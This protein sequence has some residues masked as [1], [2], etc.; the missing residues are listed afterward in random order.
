MMARRLYICLLMILSCVC[1]QA[2]IAVGSWKQ[3]PVFGEVTDLID[4][5][6]YVWYATGGCLYSYDK[7]DDETRFYSGCK[8][9]TG[10]TVKFIRHDR[11]SNVLAVAFADG[12]IDM[13]FP[14]G[15]LVNL[16]EIRDAGSGINRAVNDIRFDRNEMFVTTGSGLVI[17]DIERREV[18]ESRIYNM[19]LRT[20]IPTPQYLF[21]ACAEN[22]NGSYALYRVR[23]DASINSFDNLA[24]VCRYRDLIDDFCAL[25]DSGTGYAV[26][27]NGRLDY[28]EI[29][30]GGGCVFHDIRLNGSYCHASG[31]SADDSGVVRFISSDGVVGHY[32]GSG[33][34]VADMAMPEEFR[35]NLMASCRGLA[36]VWLAGP[37]GI[38]NYRIG[39]DLT[40]LREKSVPSDAITFTE[41]SN[42]FPSAGNNGFYVANLGM[43]RWHP[44]GDGDRFNVRLRL[45]NVS[46]DGIKNIDPVGV[47]ANTGP[48]M[49]SQSRYGKYIFSPTGIVEDPDIPG[50][51]YIGSGCEGVYVIEDG[52]EIIKFDNT[53]STINKHADYYCGTVFVTID[54]DGNLWV[55]SRAGGVKHPIAILPADKRKYKDLKLL[56]KEDWIIA[57]YD[58]YL[59]VRDIK[60]LHCR[61]SD[62][63]FGVDATDRRGFLAVNHRGTLADPADDTYVGWS[64]MTDQD[65]NTFT[66]QSWTCLV[67]DHR[68]HVWFGTTSGVISVTDP[69]RACDSGFRINRIKVPRNDGSG[70]ADYLL[71]DDHIVAIA[72]DSSNRKWIG[73]NGSGLYLVSEDG[74]EIISHFTTGNSPLPTNIITALYCDPN[75]NSLF[76][77]TLSGLYEYSSASSPPAPDYSDVYAYPNPVTPEYSG[78]ITVTGLMDNSLVKI[79]DSGMRLVYQTT[80]EGGM[81]VWNGCNAAGQ[82]VHSGVY[83]VLASSSGQ[84]SGSSSGDV[85]AKILVVN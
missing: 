27:R 57:D 30:S 16:P 36:S 8:D 70:L 32:S 77:G 39:K 17:Y 2:G 21:L 41:V 72:V 5:D 55:C 26:S 54:M 23:R 3:Y 61:F 18:K 48:G 64:Y 80:S 79:M 4:T 10:A 37:D 63:M 15:S 33:S 50:R 60:I 38:G 68:G 81:A 84:S 1:V 11:D 13:I 83:Y 44:A 47:S 7:D 56:T 20:V 6:R 40:V 19:P 24:F 73:T 52:R 76:V 85:V 31:M 9:L 82:R 28:I 14:D 62:M 25:D 65:G 49:S 43:S 42:I 34:L 51:L 45:N 46:K 35:D 22:E 67:E 75:S 29:D 53:N 74:D 58:L 66:P 69:S 71:G 12:N 78:P 59:R